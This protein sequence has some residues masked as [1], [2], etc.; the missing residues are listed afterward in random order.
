MSGAQRYR[1]DG[2][3]L[4][5]GTTEG[6][7]LVVGHWPRSSLG[8]FT[9]VMVQRGDGTRLLLAPSDEIAAFVS[10][11][12]TFDE[13]LVVP[14]VVVDRTVRTGPDGGAWMLSA[15]PLE[16][17]AT[18]GRRPALGLLLAAVPSRLAVS[19][20]WISVLHPI[21]RATTGLRTRGS[22]GSGRTEWYGVTGLRTVTGGTASWAGA[23]LGELAPVRPPVTFGFASV[24]PGPS[25]ARVV[26]TVAVP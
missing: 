13:V 24:P 16:L 14:D 15:G 1:F 2:W 7:R 6:T 19:P 20:A 10:A 12:Y 11:T 25:L 9:D 21:A 3:I 4:G 5:T 22:A 17:T 8:P 23:P 26:T 18:V